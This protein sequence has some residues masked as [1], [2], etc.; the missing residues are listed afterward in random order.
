MRKQHYR[1]AEIITKLREAD[2][3]PGDDKEG[4][5]VIQALGVARVAESDWWRSTGE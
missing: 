5:E 1:P 4:A 2:H 3:W